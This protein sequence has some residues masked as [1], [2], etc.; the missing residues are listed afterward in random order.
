VAAPVVSTT[1]WLRVALLFSCAQY[2]SNRLLPLRFKV[3]WVFRGARQLFV[4]HSSSAPRRTD[5]GGKTSP[6]APN[7][8]ISHSTCLKSLNVYPLPHQN[9]AFFSL[10]NSLR[11]EAILIKE[12]C[13]HATLF[14]NLESPWWLFIV[15]KENVIPR[16]YTVISVFWV[17]TNLEKSGNFVCRGMSWN[18]APSLG[19][20]IKTL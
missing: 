19:I 5:V 7:A 2:K 14:P 10:W 11:D 6:F 4:L 15:F 1:I 3:S 8:S 17:S 20:F 16:V 12:A 18:L 13:I 9:C